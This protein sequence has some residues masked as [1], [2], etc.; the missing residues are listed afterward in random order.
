MALSG[1]T[2]TTTAMILLMLVVYFCPRTEMVPAL[3][4]KL[5]TN[6]NSYCHHNQSGLCGFRNS[7]VPLSCTHQ[8]RHRETVG[9][10]RCGRLTS[11]LIRHH[12]FSF[13]YIDL[14]FQ[15]K[16]NISQ[17]S[18]CRDFSLRGVTLPLHE[19]LVYDCAML[20]VP[21]NVARDGTLTVENGRGEGNTFIFR[22]PS[23]T[24]IHPEKT[25]L[26][27]WHVFFYLHQDFIATSSHLPV[28]VQSA[29]P[30]PNVSYRVS[31]V[32]CLDAITPNCGNYNALN[33][34][35]VVSPK[36]NEWTVHLPIW[37][38]PGSYAVTVQIES[39]DCPPHTGCYISVSPKFE[40]EPN[41][42]GIWMSV[43]MGFFLIAVLT[44]LLIF[45]K[46]L[47]T[48]RDKL[49]ALQEVQPTVL[50]IYIA[51]NQLYM[52]F[53]NM[54]AD[55]LKNTCHLFPYLV[56][57]DVGI[58]DPNCWTRDHILKADK[59]MFIIPGNPDGESSTPIRNQWIVAL[60]YLSGHHFTTRQVSR[61]VAAVTLPSSGTIPPEILHVQ[62][63]K[64]V[65][66]VAA[67]VTWL[68]GGTRLDEMF[69]WWPVIR[70]TKKVSYTWPK[71]RLAALRASATALKVSEPHTG[72]SVM[73]GNIYLLSPADQIPVPRDN[74]SKH[75]EDSITTEGDSED[76]DSVFDPDIPSFRRL[77][78][79]NNNSKLSVN[80]EHSEKLSD[81]SDD[82]VF[83]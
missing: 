71:M 56:D 10:D 20:R 26:S 80:S 8:L 46:R 81:C 35:L 63:F 28:T 61:K 7:T 9:V 64:L 74:L 27:D 29:D 16:V 5:F 45:N 19:T 11:M 18:I 33:S 39:S 55:F 77:L 12:W 72:L 13:T 48:N 75:S 76:S 43:A 79:V 17:G 54:F 53:I 58:E 31:I 51:E 23:Y 47:R 4:N 60:N 50:L 65:D 44:F 66:Q 2:P 69:L 6:F 25:D 82:D 67:L 78:E 32:K 38:N 57:R 73:Y 36:E 70:L 52:E 15:Y 42:L 40:I 1:L 83:T 24:R 37:S 41:L 14:K 34:T 59:V 62:R 30:F 22:I 68:H 49:Q 3:C 21:G